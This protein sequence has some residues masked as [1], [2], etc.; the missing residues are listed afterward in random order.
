MAAGAGRMAGGGREARSWRASGAFESDGACGGRP[1][2][3]RDDRAVPRRPAILF[4][5]LGQDAAACHPPT[6]RSVGW[7][8]SPPVDRARSP[9]MLPDRPLTLW[10]ILRA[11]QDCRRRPSASAGG[12]PGS[13]ARR[14]AKA[15]ADLITRVA[16]GSS[17]SGCRV[18]RR[19]L[20]R[21]RAGSAR[22]CA[23][24]P[25]SSGASGRALA[26]APQSR[27]PPGEVLSGPMGAIAAA[28]P[29]QTAGCRAVAA[30]A[31]RS[32][33]NS[34]YS[35]AT[36]VLA[37]VGLRTRARRKGVV[38]SSPRRSVVWV[39]VIRPPGPA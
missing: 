24:V 13:S 28:M 20:R 35:L 18:V 10:L 33:M 30:G 36:A 11:V 39:A 9:R 6:S 29:P 31:M 1:S 38:E 14:R 17:A 12:D 7:S 37:D 3:R 32:P 27:P 16:S 2:I 34:G 26:G 19:R 4:T 5:R 15:P 25:P 21:A 23:G 22:R 8:S